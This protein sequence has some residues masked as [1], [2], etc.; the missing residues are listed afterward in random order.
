MKIYTFYDRVKKF[1]CQLDLID[2]WKKS[3][4]DNGF[5]PIVLTTAD[6]QHH[7]YY[8]TYVASMNE[9]H[10]EITGK[11]LQTYGL[12]CYLRWLA[13]SMVSDEYILTS[14][15]DIINYTLKPHHVDIDVDHVYMM[16]AATPCMVASKPTLFKSLCHMFVDVM[17]E[18]I[19]RWRGTFDDD[20]W[21]H[22][23][24]FFA[25]IFFN[26]SE[27]FRDMIISKY[28]IKVNM[29]WGKYCYNYEGPNT[30]KKYPTV[31]YSHSALHTY[32][33]ELRGKKKNIESV[34]VPDD[35]ITKLQ[36]DS[37]I[38]WNRNYEKNMHRYRLVTIESDM[39]NV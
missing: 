6:V 35:N 26:E 38:D 33:P 2:M 1:P 11:Y 24:E 15:Y 30:K 9:L 37:T 13:Y 12:S 10:Y 20:V 5:E 3:W 22:D 4:S 19:D 28:N 17:S 21:L 31:H 7:E 23:Q 14:D 16:N 34:Q 39:N 27:E 25:R 8:D 29:D 32:A 36:F 18:N